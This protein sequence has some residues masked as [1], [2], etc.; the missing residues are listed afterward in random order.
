MTQY[1]TIVIDP[2][3]PGPGAAY[4]CRV[5]SPIQLIP[6]TCMSGIQLAAM[7]IP[8]IATPDSQLWIWATSRNIGDAFLLAQLWGFTY[9]ANFIW[10][11]R[12]GM[13]RHCRHDAEFLLYCARHGAL[14]CAPKRCPAQT[15]HWPK[16][17]AHSAK[18]AEAYEFIRS[19]SEEPRIDIFSRQTRPGFTPWGNQCGLLDAPSTKHQEP[20]TPH[21]EPRT[22]NQEPS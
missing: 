3:W 14:L 7:R 20:S 1:K 2:P 5:N 21:Q 12:P 4:R 11:K 10:Q 15:Q 6:Y 9:R 19:F 22:K 17:K 13:G 8:D 16:P 18:P